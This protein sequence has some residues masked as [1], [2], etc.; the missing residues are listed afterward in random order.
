MK[1]RILH[2]TNLPSVC[3][4]LQA[5][6][7]GGD[8][9]AW[10]D[11][12][13]QGPLLAL[14]L[15]ELAARRSA[16]FAS[17]GWG[18]RGRILALFERRNEQLR[19]FRAYDEVVLWF[20]HDLLDQ[21]QLLQLLNWFS[22]QT[23]GRTRLTL[24]TLDHYPG[25]YRFTGL[26]VLKPAQLRN[27]P[28]KRLEVSLN[29]F[30]LARRAWEAVTASDPA[31]LQVFGWPDMSSLPYLKDAL[32][33][34]QEEYPSR[35]DGLSRSERQILRAVY[36]GAC[37]PRHI[38]ATAQRMEDR[39]FMSEKAFRFLLRKLL[40]DREPCIRVKK[41]DR[42]DDIEAEA[43][44]YQ[45]IVITAAGFKVLAED[46]DYVFMNGVDRWVGGVHISDACIWRRNRHNKAIKRTYA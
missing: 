5:A 7:I 44:Y 28:A 29:Q 10:Q 17:Q 11:L 27:L 35:Q 15:D 20:D 3:R 24:I 31:R 46:R 13:Y 43:F 42:V 4:S 16:Y 33:R 6:D 21:L 18:A 25:I 12:L 1:H 40:R 9:L 19:A 23:L 32:S 22:Q 8:T 36:A 37:Y 45:N 34:L 30:E 41:G 39:P 26:E 14:P 2:I 38:Y